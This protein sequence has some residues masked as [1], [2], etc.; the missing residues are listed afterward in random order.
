MPARDACLGLNLNDN[1]QSHAYL[2]IWFQTC[3]IA[4]IATIFEKKF[5]DRSDHNLLWKQLSSAR[6]AGP[7]DAG[8]RSDLGDLPTPS[9]NFLTS[10]LHVCGEHVI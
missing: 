1:L 4:T 10:R 7:S 5:S 2:K 8:N 9:R 6:D 3:M